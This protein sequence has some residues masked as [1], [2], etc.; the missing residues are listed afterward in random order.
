MLDLAALKAELTSDPLGRG[1]ASLG[2]ADCADILNA[3][4]RPGLAITVTGDD[5]MNKVI[6]WS[7]VEA[8]TAAKR[9]TLAILLKAGNLDLTASGSNA[10]TY[11]ASLFGAASATRGN[12]LALQA[13]RISRAAELG[14]PPIGHP[15]V[16]AARAS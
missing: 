6:V 5:L 11:L 16:A 1:Y 2:D 3:V 15:D 10:R 9:D 4:N 12:F 14:L 7:E 8:L 13:P